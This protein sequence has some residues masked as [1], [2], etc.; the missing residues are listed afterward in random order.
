[1]KTIHRYEI[2]MMDVTKIQLPHGAEVLCVDVRDAQRQDPSMQDL[3]I[4]H[5]W[6]KVDTD[7]PLVDAFI[8][9]HGTGHKLDAYET[10]F[11]PGVF[12]NTFQIAKGALIFHAFRYFPGVSN[13]APPA[14]RTDT[15][16]DAAKGVAGGIRRA[17]RGQGRRS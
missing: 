2:S 4:A 7:Q 5:L 14:A 17:L 15:D 8:G 3:E 13:E 12:I 10:T 6:A 16:A 1:M 11:G 9:I